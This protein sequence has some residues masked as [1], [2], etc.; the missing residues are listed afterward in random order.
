MGPPA[1]RGRP[2]RERTNASRLRC[3]PAVVYRAALRSAAVKRNSARR[4][5]DSRSVSQRWQK[6]CGRCS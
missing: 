5:D 1:P 4:R 6:A 2:G 3:S